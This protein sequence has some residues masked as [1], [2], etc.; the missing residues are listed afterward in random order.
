[1]GDE[2]ANNVP[3]VGV[4]ICD[5]GEKIA[6]VL[7]T[8]ALCQQAAAQTDVAYAYRDSF[9]CNKDGQERIRKAIVEHQLDRVLVAGCSPR[10]VEMLFRQAVQPTGMDASYLNVINIREHVAY[11]HA[12]VPEAL[13]KAAD[14]IEMGVA[15]LITTSTAPVHSGRVVKSALVIG[16]G[17]SA[18]TVALVLADGGMRV[19][20]VERSGI[21]GGSVPDL[22]ERTRSLVAEKSQAILKHPLV[23]TLFNAHITEVSGH[24]G[25]YEVRVQAGDQS[26]TYA[27]GSIVVDNGAQAKTLG[28]SRWFDRTRV[29]TQAEFETELDRATEPGKMLEV[30]D[31][32]M[33]LCAEESQLKHCSRVCCNIGIRQAIRVKQ[34]NPNANVTVLFRE[35]YLGGIDAAYEEEFT[36]ARKLDVTFF[37]Y[38]RDRPPVIGDQTVDVIDTLTGEPVRVPF[39]RVVLTMPLIPHDNSNTFAALLGL[40]QDEV[41]FLAEPRV[42]LRPGRFADPG[43]YVLGSAQQPADTAEALFQ[44]YLTSS[45]AT[46]FLSQEKISVDTPV[47]SIDAS[48]C[49]GCGNCPQVCPT[50]A[51]HLEKR[52]G[53]LSLSEVDEIRCIGCGNC[54]VVCPVKAITLPGWDNNEIPTQ[55]SAALQTRQNGGPKIVALACEWSA[56]GAADIAGSRRIPYPVN[57][58]LLRMN[59]SARFDPYH[60]LWAFLSGADGVFLGACPP[61]EC[62]YGTGNLYAQERVEKLKTELKAHGVDPR[63]LRL[64]FLTVDDGAK[65]ARAITE[66]TDEIGSQVSK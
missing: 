25:D 44:A 35:L 2:I 9:P 39:D 7:D 15:R 42:R 45:R 12:D 63:R 5:C 38:R 8:Q 19:I 17:L 61:G 54:V 11:V 41:G 10:L 47:A 62:H 43:I 1:M 55:I 34:Q 64:E 40:P 53:V 29:K 50:L 52:D 13:S 51:I 20:L 18:L 28:S 6:R 31:I 16:S 4:I 32:V 33:I 30:K 48:L 27:I 60:I 46:R 58:R 3:R 23:D 36:Q 26:A 57:V 65:F 56:Y 21:L 24:P 37:R 14:L 59:C 22:Q 66:F 49:T